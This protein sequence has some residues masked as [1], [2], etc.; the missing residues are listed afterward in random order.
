MQNYLVTLRKSD[1]RAVF[2]EYLADSEFDA[3]QK[4]NAAYILEAVATEV[5][6]IPET[7]IQELARIGE[8]RNGG[9]TLTVRADRY[10]MEVNRDIFNR[11]SLAIDATDEARLLAHWSGFVKANR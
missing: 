5:S 9:C 3:K 2:E 7:L 1:G 11:H 6:L 10:H 4:A 8:I